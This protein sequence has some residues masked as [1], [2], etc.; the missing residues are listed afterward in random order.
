MLLPHTSSRCCPRRTCCWMPARR[1]RAELR[2]RTNGSASRGAV[3]A[4]AASAGIRSSA[5]SCGV[6]RR[7]GRREE[8]EQ[9]LGVLE[10]PKLPGPSAAHTAAAAGAG[11]RQSSDVRPDTHSTRGRECIL[12]Q[13][14]LE[15]FANEFVGPLKPGSIRYR[16]AMRSVLEGARVGPRQR[17]QGNEA[18]PKAEGGAV[19]PLA[20]HCTL[21]V[22]GARPLALCLRF[23]VLFGW[24][25]L[26]EI[27]EGAP[28]LADR[29][30]ASR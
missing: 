3:G 7:V 23:I 24:F 4:V 28:S 26:I 15:E 11:A 20:C 9:Q 1:W 8:H 16:S 29:P 10:E 21:A 2:P 22:E 18:K 25:A 27:L 30:E 19:E 5:D 14:Q 17:G 6:G 12:Y 13:S